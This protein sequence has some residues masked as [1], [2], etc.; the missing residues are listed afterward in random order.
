MAFTGPGTSFGNIDGGGV[1][2]TADDYGAS[3][4]YVCFVTADDE[5][6]LRILADKGPEW[7]DEAEG[8]WR[9]EEYHWQDKDLES[10]F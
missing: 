10:L 8:V 4:E 9:E 2:C 3:W 6:L 1:C 7:A 5:K